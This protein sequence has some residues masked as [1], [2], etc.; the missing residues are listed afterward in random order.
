MSEVS[1]FATRPGYG[2]VV[3]GVWM[4]GPEDTATMLKALDAGLRD[5]PKDA[6]LQEWRLQ[7]LNTR[8]RAFREQWSGW[9][10]P[11]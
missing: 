11:T 10:E 5:H 7:V 2:R 6:K 8:N 9:F 4:G 3:V 1:G